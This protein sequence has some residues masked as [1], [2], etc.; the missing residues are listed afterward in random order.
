MVISNAGGGRCK[1]ES[2]TQVAQA[3]ARV[4]VT[5]GVD[6]KDYPMVMEPASPVPTTQSLEKV[7]ASSYKATMKVNGQ[8]VATML[9]EVSADGN[10]LSVMTTGVGSLANSATVTV[11]DRR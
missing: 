4:E 8:T 1:T 11:F 2:S 9:N 5:Y 7:S 6:G 3:T 10:T